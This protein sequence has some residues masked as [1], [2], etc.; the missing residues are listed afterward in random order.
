MNHIHHPLTGL[1]ESRA[2]ES[3]LNQDTSNVLKRP[4][5]IYY[6]THVFE[7]YEDIPLVF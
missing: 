4:N 3:I 6:F 7:V 1:A 5:E 2:N